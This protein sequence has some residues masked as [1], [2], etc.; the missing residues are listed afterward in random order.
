[1]HPPLEEV[2]NDI[3]YDKLAT[4]VRLFFII[5]IFVPL[6]MKAK[7]VLLGLSGGIDSAV[8][9][10]LLQEQ[11]YVVEAIT[12]RFYEP[13]GDQ[14]YIQYA[15]DLATRLGIVHHIYDARALFEKRVL[16]YFEQ[17]YLQGTTPFPC[18]KCNPEVKFALLEQQA[19]YLGIDYIATGH[20]AQVLRGSDG[21]AIH[22]GVDPDKDQ[23]FF[24]WGLCSTVLS[25]LLLPLGG[26]LKTEVREMA[27]RRGFPCFASKKDSMGICFCPGDYRAFLRQRL[28][29]SHFPSGNFVDTSGNILG[30]HQGIAFYTI[31]QRRGLGLSLNYPVFVKQIDV[32]SNQIVLDRLLGMYKTSFVV[33]GLVSHIPRD[34]LYSQ[35]WICKI[36]YRKQATVC[37]VRPMEDG[38]CCIELESPL[39]SIAA[40]QTAVFYDQDRIIGGAFII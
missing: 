16:S 5:P 14:S 26:Y 32:D 17:S 6:Y 38:L 9:A 2:S 28:S 19:S 27:L 24:I 3:F 15:A 21:W 30:S 36:R 40:G 7:R 39:E 12:F 1:M 23:S 34:I 13:T 10:M 18:A 4:K 8:S 25:H 37:R 31:G 35:S 33:E 11:G 20:Y 29:E 22:K